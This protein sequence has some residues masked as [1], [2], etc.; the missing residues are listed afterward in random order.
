[1][2][3]RII[4]QSISLSVVAATMLVLALATTQPVPAQ[5]YSVIHTFSGDKD[6][7][8]PFPGFTID[9]SGTLYGAARGGPSGRGVAYKL[10]NSGGG[11]LL[12]PLYS[13]TKSDDGSGPNAAL[14]FGPD[15]ALYGTNVLGG[16]GSCV[17]GGGNPGCGTVFRLAPGPNRPT[18][19]LSPW[20]ET[21]V[22]RFQGGSDGLYP[23]GA[24]VFDKDG[25]LYG[26]TSYGGY[27]G[28]YCAGYGCGTIYKLTSSG[29]GNY[30]E[31]VL[32]SFTNG[33][34]GS[35]PLGAPVLDQLGNLYGTAANGG[36]LGNCN[37]ETCGVVWKLSPSDGN[38]MESV[39]H[40]FNGDD[41]FGSQTG[42][43][44][45]NSG[46]LYGSTM[47]G[48]PGGAGVVFEL[49][50]SGDNW[51]YNMLHSFP[52]QWYQGPD[53]SK[54][55]MDKDGNL[56]GTIPTGGLYTFGEV[57]K[58]T[59]TDTGWDYSTV[60][61]FKGGSDGA[62]PY[63]DLVFDKDGNLYGTAVQGGLHDY[64]NGYGVAFKIAL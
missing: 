19:A 16:G 8:A 6:G 27:Q 37:S 44:F 1:M 64:P 42:L 10:S 33:T 55:L 41:G 3:M 35:Y 63:G 32:Y 62:L 31:S 56:Y 12:T 59:K 38:W 25:N 47:G 26:T 9:K 15:G 24:V 20:V 52:G 7:A 54:L 46:N 13:F 57:Y 49:S 14:V 2:K 28:G 22:Y 29:G 40:Y 36:Q 60:Y 17:D 61:A 21:V 5:T 45:D 34:D 4:K 58:L 23:E 51:D 48:G 18:T 30:A 39:I 53:Q 43:I 50:P 11:W